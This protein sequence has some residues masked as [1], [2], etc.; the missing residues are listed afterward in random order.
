MENHKDILELENERL[1]KLLKI[2]PLTPQN[3]RFFETE[4]GFISL[5]FC[6]KVYNRV[7]L[8]RAFPFTAE[9]EYI[10]VREVDEKQDEIGLIEDLNLFSEETKA[11]LNRQLEIRYFMPK[12]QRIYSIKE[13]YGHTQWSVLTDKGKCKFS[14]HSGSANAVFQ[15]NNRV[16]IKDSIENRY[17]IE[18]ITK[19][20]PK[21]M[22]KLDLYL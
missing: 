17:E 21:E 3:A 12:I 4:G 20:T 11:I 9:N 7:N 5:E 14:T 22:K 18:D 13:Q 16:L 19:L 6:N 8:I 15:I 2:N 10:S 1:E